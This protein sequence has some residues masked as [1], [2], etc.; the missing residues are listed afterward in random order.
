[1]TLL[2][3]DTAVDAAATALADA[4]TARSA[5]IDAADITPE[6]RKT[7]MNPLVLQSALLFAGIDGKS[8]GIHLS[9]SARNLRSV[10]SAD[11]VS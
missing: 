9:G 4:I 10:A 5:F 7:L 3:V 1:M 6:A 8:L 11:G 2:D